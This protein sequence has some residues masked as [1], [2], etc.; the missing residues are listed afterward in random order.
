MPSV[1]PALQCHVDNQPTILDLSAVSPEVGLW[2]QLQNGR[3]YESNVWELL[4]KHKTLTLIHTFKPEVED[5]ENEG[6]EPRILAKYDRATHVRLKSLGDLL[7]E[8]AEHE[9]HV[10]RPDMQEFFERKTRRKNPRL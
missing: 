2:E 5:S 8:G 10:F 1:P 9:Y 4:P 7:A 3:L 6:Q